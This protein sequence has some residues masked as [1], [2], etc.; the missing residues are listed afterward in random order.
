[1]T[2]VRKLLWAWLVLAFLAGIAQA[3][4]EKQAAGAVPVI[5]IEEPVYDFQQVSQGAVVKHDFRVLNQGKA[6]LEI[7]SVRPG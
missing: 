1:M 2:V 7:K 3:A 6:P 5:H 4:E